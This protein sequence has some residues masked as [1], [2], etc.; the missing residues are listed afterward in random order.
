MFIYILDFRSFIN[1]QGNTIINLFYD[2]LIEYNRYFILNY[3]D[4]ITI[5]QNIKTDTNISISFKELTK[6]LKDMYN[7]KIIFYKL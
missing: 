4:S 6:N 2:R 1:E 5:Y 3:S 7:I